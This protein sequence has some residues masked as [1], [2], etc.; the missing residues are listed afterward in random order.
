MA[1]SLGASIKIGYFIDIF[2]KPQP[3]SSGHPYSAMSMGR[4]IVFW[5]RL[6]MAATY[7]MNVPLIFSLEL[8]QILLVRPFK[9]TIFK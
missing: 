1:N 2:D 5:M 7:P 4:T 9:L 3:I 6:G 8:W